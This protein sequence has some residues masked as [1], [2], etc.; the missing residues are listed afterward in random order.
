VLHI[1]DMDGT[2]LVGTTASLVIAERTG[3]GTELHQ[4]EEE[5]AQ[6]ALTTVEFARSLHQLWQGLDSD[7]VADAFATAPWIGSIPSVV[8]DIRSR[9]HVAVVLTMS[10]DFF[11]DLL[12]DWQ[13]NAVEAS[14]FPA[15]PLHGTLDEAL[16]LTPEDKPR[17]VARYAD[18]LNLQPYECV[19]Y[20][21]SMSDAPLFDVLPN[22]VAVNATAALERVAS[23]IY[24]GS[25][26]FEAYE[27][28]RSL[29]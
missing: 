12:L 9:G 2:M 3:T 25:D 6:G 24:R 8:E 5:F 7:V 15:L 17:L 1:F 18:A 4:L 14:R 23:A 29:T 10:P 20:G 28:G 13:F 16:I 19:A 22:T 11:A 27:L 26:L 21:D